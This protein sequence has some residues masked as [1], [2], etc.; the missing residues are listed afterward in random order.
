MNGCVLE[1]LGQLWDYQRSVETLAQVGYGLGGIQ[2]RIG[3]WSETMETF[4]E[5]GMD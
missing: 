4:M 3:L 1:R 5:K 2:V